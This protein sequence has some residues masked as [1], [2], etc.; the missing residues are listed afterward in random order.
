M[1][2]KKWEFG[3]RGGRRRGGERCRVACGCSRCAGRIRGRRG[4]AARRGRHF[5]SERRVDVRVP[6]RHLAWPSQVSAELACA[7]P[8]GIPL[9][10]PGEVVSAAALA[11]LIKLRDAGC[12]ISA[13]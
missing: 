4:G 10:L 5:R 8:P 6:P 13:G 12:N 3:G 11:E 9:I 7:Y 1:F 2:G